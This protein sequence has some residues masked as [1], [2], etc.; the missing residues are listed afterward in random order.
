MSRQLN[1][2]NYIAIADWMVKDLGLSGRELLAYAIIYGFSQDEKSSFVGSLEYLSAW[3]NISH[4]NNVLR[5]LKSLQNKNLITKQKIKYPDR[6]IMCAY[7]VIAAKGKATNYKHIFILPWMIEKLNLNDRE[8]ILYALIYGFSSAGSDT[9]CTASYEYF[10]E[11]LNVRK[12]HIKDRYLKKLKENGLLEISV[13]HGQIRYKALIP[14]F[15][16]TF[17]SSDSFSQN[18]STVPQFES[19]FP[20]NDNQNFPKTIDDNL[21]NNKLE[22]ILVLNNNKDVQYQTKEEL[23]VVVNKNI[24]SDMD[25]SISYSLKAFTYKLEKDYEMY[26]KYRTTAI[27]IANF[28]SGYARA[29]QVD[30]ELFFGNMDEEGMMFYEKGSELLLKI[31]VNKRFATRK[32]ELLNLSDSEKTK[33]YNI[34]SRMFSK[35]KEK[36]ISYK[37]DKSSYLIGVIEN[38]ISQNS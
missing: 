20:Q 38:I 21:V 35:N 2:K 13:H 31:I 1:D 11:W 23:S 10:A 27:D 22:K 5:V 18:D 16:S 25:F 17:D 37:K 8:L 33:I 9:Y 26:Q 12:D 3:L 29:A 36:R 14:Q 19:T 24:I 4:S 32:E 7:S 30:L 6:Q 15:D 34:S 28:M